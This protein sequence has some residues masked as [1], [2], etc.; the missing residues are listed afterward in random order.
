M[1]GQRASGAAGAQQPAPSSPA[2]RRAG[3]VPPPRLLTPRA[4]GRPGGAVGGS[5]AGS[6]DL[7]Q[8]PF[9]QGGAGAR[10]GGRP[11]ASRGGSG[12]RDTNP[13]LQSGPADAAAAGAP[14]GNPFLQARGMPGEPTR[15]QPQYPALLAPLRH[16]KSGA[17]ASFWLAQATSITGPLAA[18]LSRG[19][20]CPEARTAACS[21]CRGWVWEPDPDRDAGYL[22][23]LFIV[24]AGAAGARAGGGGAGGGA[25]R[26]AGGAAQGHRRRAGAGG[27]RR[28]RR[29][30][31]GGPAGLAEGRRAQRTLR[32]PS[33]G[34]AGRRGGPKPLPADAG[35][36]RRAASR[37]VPL[38]CLA[39]A[40]RL[41]G[42][43]AARLSGPGMRSGGPR[44]SAAGKQPAPDTDPPA[45]ITPTRLR[46]NV[47]TR[48]A[49]P[50]ARPP[51]PPVCGQSSDRTAHAAAGSGSPTARAG[52]G[53]DAGN[54]G[55]EAAAFFTP[56]ASIEEPRKPL[57]ARRF[58]ARP[59]FARATR[60]SVSVGSSLESPPSPPPQRLLQQSPAPGAGSG[61][62]SHWH[63]ALPLRACM[64]LSQQAAALHAGRRAGGGGRARRRRAARRRARRGGGAQQGGGQRREPGPVQPAGGAGPVRVLNLPL[65]I[66]CC[67]RHG[68]GLREALAG[69]L[70]RAVVLAAAAAA[71]SVRQGQHRL[72]ADPWQTAGGPERERTRQG[73]SELVQAMRQ[74][75]RAPGFAG[76]IRSKALQLAAAS[77]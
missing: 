32:R 39:L 71:S 61:N 49:A 25:G 48:M 53:K 33:A 23:M 38:A 17:A 3:G 10:A 19:T 2:A 70:P 20:P 40:A 16:W 35:A 63:R 50:P 11:G 41:S 62:A 54:D 67:L 52:A 29:R 68:R 73:H 46:Q 31:P 69:F 18:C 59:V 5:A 75:T 28:G 42:P 56:A 12:D 15:G 64:F 47:L 24:S 37:P 34:A 22:V 72:R 58:Q 9:L 44:G 74:G 57:A 26:R 55:D 21:C 36:S 60:M 76:W 1:E 66:S 30:A 4:G 77:R 65:H 27:R 8:N 7:D 51:Q 14:G 13:Y 43:V 45:N 6:G